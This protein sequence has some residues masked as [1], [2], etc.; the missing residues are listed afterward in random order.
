MA[1]K[2]H[3]IQFYSTLFSCESPDLRHYPHP[4]YFPL[5][6]DD[7]LHTLNKGVEDAEIQQTI[8]GM[9]PLK[10]P[11]PDGLHAVFYQTQWNTVG[12]PLC[13]LVKDVFHDK[14]LPVGLNSTLIALIPKTESR[15]SLKMYRPISLCNVAYKTITKVL[16][17]RRQS[18]LPSLIGPH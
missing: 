4:N 2:A 16:A 8:F 17:N 3:V 11:G 14:Y 6:E 10:A 12:S 13:R 7:L 5:I 9:H 1:I 18:I 15:S